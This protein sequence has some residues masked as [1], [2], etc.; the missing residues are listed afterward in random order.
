MQSFAAISRLQW[1]LQVNWNTF[2]CLP[3][4][5]NIFRTL[6]IETCRSSKNAELIQGIKAENE[7]PIAKG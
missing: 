2:P 1:V 6:Y 4:I 3:M 5:L 7:R